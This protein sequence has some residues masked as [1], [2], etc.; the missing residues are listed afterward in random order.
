MAG[1]YRAIKERPQVRREPAAQV[2]QGKQGRREVLVPEDRVLGQG[3]RA[4]DEHEQ[5][6]ADVRVPPQVPQVIHCPLLS[7]GHTVEP[8]STSCQ[9]GLYMLVQRCYLDQVFPT[10]AA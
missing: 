9:A 3:H 2:G 7:D 5:E 4:V 1:G 6:R 8:R 10:P